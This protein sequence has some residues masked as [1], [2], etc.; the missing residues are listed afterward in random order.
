[1]PTFFKT[2]DRLLK[3]DGLGLIQAITIRDQQY[4]S[5]RR[6][7][8][9]IQR[10]IFPGGLL[11]SL[12]RM[13]DCVQGN[14]DLTLTHLEDIGRDYAETLRA[15][16]R[17][18]AANRA[19]IAALGLDDVFQRLWEFYFCYCE[20][21]FRERSTSAVQAVYAKPLNRDRPIATTI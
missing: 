2:V 11:P 9:F 15:W 6:S 1:M 17:R 18:F 10:H 20:G 16:R 13:A 12:A 3:P 19:Q 4:E 21:A 5:Y 7:V 8:D 14:T